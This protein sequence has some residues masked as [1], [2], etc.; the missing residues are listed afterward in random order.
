MVY[1]KKIEGKIN[2]P[3]I[4]LL[5]GFCSHKYVAL[6][7]KTP[8]I[9]KGYTI[10][11]ITFNG[12]GN[13]RGKIYH[14]IQ[15]VKKYKNYI[16]NLHKNIILIGHSMGAT[17][18]IS[19]A[20]LKNVKKV[21]VISGLHD[22]RAFYQPTLAHFLFSNVKKITND[23][24]GNKLDVKELNRV[25]KYIEPMLPINVSLTK[26]QAKKI[27]LIHQTLDPIVPMAHF[28]L[29]KKKFHVPKSKC[30]VLPQVGHIFTLYN[31]Q[32]HNFILKHIEKK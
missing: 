10:H 1:Y 23:I 7:W 22:N 3:E 30:L 28:K 16:K 32:I 12:H 21:F 4:M 15:S 25:M 20:E 19:L 26:N 31:W 2:S 14:W 17:M 27:H 18:C 24:K 8:Y 5:H 9:K 6:N 11:A 13:Q 29:N